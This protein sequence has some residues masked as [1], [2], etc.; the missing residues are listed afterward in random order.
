MSK[1]VHFP[2]SFQE[3]VEDAIQ[4]LSRSATAFSYDYF[5]LD[6]GE[7][8]AP[9]WQKGNDEPDKLRT[10]I[11]WAARPVKANPCVYR[12]VW[13]NNLSQDDIL[14]EF[15]NYK[16]RKERK[17]SAVKKNP[18]A[19]EQTL[20]VGK[21]EKDVCGRIM[22]HLGYYYNSE[23]AGLQLVGWAKGIN[24]QIAFHIWSFEQG[25]KDYVGL[26]ERSL[27]KA[28]PSL[29]GKKH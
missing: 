1:P 4:Q 18:Q 29:I 21:V 24:L 26:F 3:T 12:I 19:F 25:M 22:T 20:Y 16:N 2:L 7:L 9:I 13:R 6:C 5:E 11:D 17:T 27:D 10:L 14:K 8:P 28:Y 23:T 15:I